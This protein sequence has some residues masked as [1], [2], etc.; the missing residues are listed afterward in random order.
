MSERICTNCNCIIDEHGKCINCGE[1]MQIE[2]ISF[3]SM[4]NPYTTS[5][6]TDDQPDE[7]PDLQNE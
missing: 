2:H 6:Q 5:N 7:D 1:T 3:G 4:L